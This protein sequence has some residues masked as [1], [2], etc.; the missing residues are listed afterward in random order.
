MI[1]TVVFVPSR[2]LVTAL[3]HPIHVAPDLVFINP[4]TRYV[5]TAAGRLVTGPRFWDSSDDAPAGGLVTTC[6]QNANETNSRDFILI[7]P[8]RGS[9][10]R[11]P[12]NSRACRF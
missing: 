11:L 9:D 5:T 4:I 1:E 2:D 7:P 3:G 12:R 8:G 10:A 6:E